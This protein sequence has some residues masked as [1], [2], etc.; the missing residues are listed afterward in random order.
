MTPEIYLGNDSL[1]NGQPNT[2]LGTGQYSPGIYPYVTIYSREM[3]VDNNYNPLIQLNQSNLSTL[4]TQ[5]QPLVGPD[6]ANLSS[7]IGCMARQRLAEPRPA[8]HRL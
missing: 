4:Y 7:P 5:L 1:R 2:N 8:P 6:V 3:P